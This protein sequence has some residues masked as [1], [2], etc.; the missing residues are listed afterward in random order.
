MILLTTLL[1]GT[2]EGMY[3]DSG[4][5]MITLE[6]PLLTLSD[7]RLEAQLWP[8]CFIWWCVTGNGATLHRKFSEIANTL[9][10]Q[11][12]LKI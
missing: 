12:W 9:F 8:T 6:H 2:L 5:S 1:R 10:A 3:I 11:I 7:L 4:P